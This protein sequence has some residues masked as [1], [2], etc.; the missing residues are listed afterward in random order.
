ML[1]IL[2]GLRFVKDLQE[3]KAA[4]EIHGLTRIKKLVCPQ[5]IT[6]AQDGEL[7]L[8][9]K[10][11]AGFGVKCE[12]GDSNP[13]TSRHQ[14]LNLARLPIPPLSHKITGYRVK[15]PLF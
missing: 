14:D 2:Q 12:R 8:W 10:L 15:I 7:S 4:A 3:N 5:K 1:I 11:G 6:W 9:L 13:H